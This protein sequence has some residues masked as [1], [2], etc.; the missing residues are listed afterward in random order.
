MLE[1]SAG[2]RHSFA[3]FKKLFPQIKDHEKAYI[4]IG[5]KLP[6]AKKAKSED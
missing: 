4:A 2:E 6:K 3:E 5:G 1:E